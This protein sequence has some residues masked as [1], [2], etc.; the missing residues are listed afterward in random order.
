MKL[1]QVIESEGLESCTDRM[2]FDEF[3]CCAARS[4]TQKKAENALFTGIFGIK[5]E[6]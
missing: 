3:S 1:F 2:K 6:R 4:K 5:Q